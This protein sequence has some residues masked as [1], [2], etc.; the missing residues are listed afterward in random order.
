MVSPDKRSAFQTLRR[1]GGEISGDSGCQNAG[2]YIVKHRS[3]NK[4]YIEK[5]L[6]PIGGNALYAFR[7]MRAMIQ[8][9]GHPHIVS[10]FAHDLSGP[11]GSIFMQQCEL[12]SLDSL[13]LR[14][15]ERRAKLPDE[16]FLWK[17]LW[18]L[19]L[20][21]CYLWSGHDYADTRRRAMDSKRVTANKEG[22]NSIIHRDLKPANIF[23]T[24]NTGPSLD[25]PSGYPRLLIGDFGCTVTTNDLATL[26]P[27]F[28]GGADPNF[29][30]PGPRFDKHVDVYGVGLILQCLGM[31]A[32]IPVPSNTMRAQY[33]L[34][35]SYRASSD[36]VERVRHCLALDPGGR[37][38]PRDLPAYVS[39]GFRLWRAGRGDDGQPLPSWAF[40]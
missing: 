33:P 24:W 21:V 27:E 39:K 16:G 11:F 29:N 34:G 26:A 37:P 14:F 3:T 15:V 2:I 25:R 28:I 17:A 36:L 12:G 9:E 35:P 1:L 18:D 13:I 30:A 5:R 19:S 7:E 6:A 8:C 20:A 31:M 10:I 23:M 4:E 38:V 22:W 40:G 32:Q